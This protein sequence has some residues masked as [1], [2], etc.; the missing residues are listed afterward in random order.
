[1]YQIKQTN[2]FRI[3]HLA[4]KYEKKNKLIDEFKNEM[5][6]C[7]EKFKRKKKHCQQFNCKQFGNLKRLQKM[8]EISILS[9]YEHFCGN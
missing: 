7:E 2:K 6:F 5:A 1:M 4:L 9:C 8:S 3:V